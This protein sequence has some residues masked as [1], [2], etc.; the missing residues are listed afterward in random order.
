MQITGYFLEATH[1]HYGFI[2]GFFCLFCIVCFIFSI[3]QVAKKQPPNMSEYSA[4]QLSVQ[5][6]PRGGMNVKAAET[7]LNSFLSRRCCEDV[8]T[9]P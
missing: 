7:P 1:S 9:T 2:R 3:S 5:S 6:G 4:V 8:L